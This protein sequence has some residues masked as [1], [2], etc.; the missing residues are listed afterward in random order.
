M[1]EELDTAPVVSLSAGPGWGKTPLLT[2]WRARSRRPF[3]W[4]AIDED[5]NDP[6]VLLTYVAA[7]L[8]RVSQFDASVFDALATP[9]VS[10]EGTAVPR[11][12]AAFAA[13][14]DAAVLVLDGLPLLH[15]PR[16]LATVA[17]LTRHVPEGSQ[18]VP[19]HEAD[20]RFTGR[21]EGARARR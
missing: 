16:C 18:L 1:L 15:N 12:A 5:D 17:E 3:A 9:G 10:I 21:A 7:A 19:L 13:M 20:P 8:D 11:V 4:V 2:Q 6:I 14:D